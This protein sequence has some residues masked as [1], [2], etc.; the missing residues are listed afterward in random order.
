MHDYKGEAKIE[1]DGS[2]T[3]KGIPFQAGERVE[4]IIRGCESTEGNGERYPLRGTPVRYTD[5]FGSL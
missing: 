2:V 1:A 4:V 3:I 5:P